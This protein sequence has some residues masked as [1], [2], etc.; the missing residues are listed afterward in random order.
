MLFRSECFHKR[1]FRRT[2]IVMWANSLTAIFGLPLLAKASYFLQIV[3]MK[4]NTSIIFLI[5]GIVLGLVAN[6][7]SVWIMSKVGRRP[8]VL[9]TL[10]ITAALWLSMGIANCFKG[11]AVTW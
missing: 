11:D 1:N 10:L 7:I 2:F 3:G 9:I 8:L 6:A 5:L 4:P